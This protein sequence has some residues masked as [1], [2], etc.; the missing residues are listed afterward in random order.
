M[1]DKVTEHNPRVAFAE[2]VISALKEI[3]VGVSDLKLGADWFLQSFRVDG[4]TYSV[5]PYAHYNG[6]PRQTAVEIA[7]HARNQAGAA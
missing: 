2:A 6:D 3:G 1:T 7:A 4:A 5:P